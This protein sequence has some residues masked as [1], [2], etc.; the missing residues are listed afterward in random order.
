MDA[1]TFIDTGYI[2]ALANTADKYHERAYATSLLVKPP[3]MTTEAVLIEIG[4]ALSGLRWRSLGF[5]IIN[6]LRQ[7][8]NIN[9]LS[10]DTDLFDRALSLYGARSDKTWGITDCIS[11]VVMQTHNLI[12][13]L[14]TDHHFEQA[15]FQNLLV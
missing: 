3:F 5:A 1:A 7:D 15:G 4:N 13:V 14:T 12:S 11:F 9:I 10:V 8:P 6:D 2:L